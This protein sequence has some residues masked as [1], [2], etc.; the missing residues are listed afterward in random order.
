MIS[1]IV[2]SNLDYAD[3]IVSSSS[4]KCTASEWLAAAAS[5]N[6]TAANLENVSR[7]ERLAKLA[8]IAA[9][10]EVAAATI[11]T[12]AARRHAKAVAAL[13]KTIALYDIRDSSG[14]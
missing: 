5:I 8:I 7:A 14:A 6:N 1:G 9:A 10:E 3:N 13:R 11:I 4:A 2:Q 12:A